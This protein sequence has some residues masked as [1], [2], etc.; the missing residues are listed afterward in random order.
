MPP[1][2]LYVVSSSLK[3]RP[4][5]YKNTTNWLAVAGTAKI[6]VCDVCECLDFTICE[7]SCGVANGQP[8]SGC[9]TSIYLLVCAVLR[10]LQLQCNHRDS[11]SP[12]HSTYYFTQTQSCIYA[13]E[14]FVRKPCISL[15]RTMLRYVWLRLCII[16]ECTLVPHRGYGDASQYTRR[17][18]HSRNW[19]RLTRKVTLHVLFLRQ[20]SLCSFIKFQP[21]RFSLAH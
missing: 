21:G 20:R 2:H 5:H 3:L 13:H 12:H 6:C 4:A 15:Y 10:T 16:T 14:A 19:W 7:I 8:T 1:L 11:A 9:D 17:V 18:A